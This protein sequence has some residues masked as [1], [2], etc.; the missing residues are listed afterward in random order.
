MIRAA[1]LTISLSLLGAATPSLA[2]GGWA[3]SGEQQLAKLVADRVAGKPVNCIPLRDIRSTQV[4]D[5]IAIVY[6]S[7]GGRLYV[8]RPDAGAGSLRRDDILVT[9]T[10]G[11]QL[12]HLDT[13]RLLD[14]GSRFEHGFVGLS[15]FV[16]YERPKTKAAQG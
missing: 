8:N 6:E 10:W 7:R 13:V 3:Q 4:L 1:A 12:C 11:S 15:T 2:K 9:K 14:W 5:G 16:P